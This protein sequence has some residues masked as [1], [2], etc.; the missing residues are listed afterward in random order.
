MQRDNVAI[1]HPVAAGDTW[2]LVVDTWSDG[3]RALTGP[4][5]LRLELRVPREGCP[6]DMVPVGATCMD[7][8]EAPNLE[9]ELPLVMF[10]FDESE[11]WCG[12]RGKRLCFDDE[13]SLACGGE[14]GTAYPYGDAHRPGVCRDDARW[15]AYDQ[16]L[17]NGW[18]RVST[19]EIDRLETLL[20]AARARAPA[21]AA[22]APP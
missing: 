4:F 2:W 5:A 3:A 12:A 8:Y 14:A 9:G 19:P 6:A 16:P 18:P 22:R 20:D 21:R 1:V 10:T 7:R 17:L 15:R 11:A 13:W